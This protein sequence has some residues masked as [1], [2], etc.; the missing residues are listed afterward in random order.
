MCSS[1]SPIANGLITY[2]SD[3][4]DPFNFGTTATYS[5]NDGFRLGGNT[6]R[7]CVGS[8]LWDGTEPECLG[9][10]VP[11]IYVL[12]VPMALDLAVT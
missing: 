8:E 10:Y 3:T 6:V 9:M 4:T 5:C 12:P 2:E 7:T 11:I 1:L